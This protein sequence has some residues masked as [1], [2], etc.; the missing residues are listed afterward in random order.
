M[1]EEE[2]EEEEEERRT[3][4]PNIEGEEEEMSIGEI[5]QN[6]NYPDVESRW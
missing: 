4:C 2:E 3:G 5:K 6:K 1:E